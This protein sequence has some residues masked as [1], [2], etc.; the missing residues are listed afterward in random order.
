MVNAGAGGPVKYHIR[1]LTRNHYHWADVVVPSPLS[2]PLT[3]VKHHGCAHHSG[4]HHG[5]HQSA[6]VDP[7]CAEV[8]CTKTERYGCEHSM[9]STGQQ[10]V[11]LNFFTYDDYSADRE[12]SCKCFR[13][14]ITIIIKSYYS[15][16]AIPRKTSENGKWLLRISKRPWQLA[17]IVASFKLSG[18][19]LRWSL[20]DAVGILAAHVLDVVCPSGIL[21]A[22]LLE[23]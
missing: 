6:G 21:D 10:S 22:N 15:G 12:W 16:M 7:R 20:L 2:S 18:T 8:L 1:F 17:P 23:G 19:L 3:T 11:I 14:V 5:G 4:G 13:G 9:A